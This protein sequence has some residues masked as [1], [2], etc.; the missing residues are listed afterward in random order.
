MARCDLPQLHRR[1]PHA[2]LAAYH[3]VQLSLLHKKAVPKGRI[4]GVGGVDAWQLIEVPDKDQR[5]H[6]LRG[7]PLLHDALED[8][9]RELSDLLH[10]DQVVGPQHLQGLL[11][12]L[13]HE[14]SP[15]HGV[16]LQVRE[17]FAQGRRQP[18]CGG[19]QKNPTVARE[20]ACTA[21]VLP[22]P[23]GPRTA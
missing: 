5:R 19:G 12:W 23:A 15:M 2:T 17:L 21:V 22:L 14:E 1:L 7:L 10:D 9:A 6:P 20:S 8:G 3:S 18:P 16:N 4:Q 13:V 11:G